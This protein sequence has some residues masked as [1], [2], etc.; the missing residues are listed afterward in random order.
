MKKIYCLLLALY[1]MIMHGCTLTP[2]DNTDKDNVD[3]DLIDNYKKIH[4]NNELNSLNYIKETLEIDQIVSE[5]YDNVEFCS[6]NQTEILLSIWNKNTFKFIRYD[7]YSKEIIWQSQT[8]NY[9]YFIDIYT[10]SGKTY[11]LC[12]DE[13]TPLELLIVDVDTGKEQVNMVTSKLPFHT[14][15]ND[16]IYF[17]VTENKQGK[18]EDAIYK[19]D[20]NAQ[21]S[22]IKN[23]TYEIDEKGKYTGEV[24]TAMNGMDGFLLLQTTKTE[25][26]RMADGNFEIYQIQL[27]TMKE[28]KYRTDKPYQFISG[29][30]KYIIASIHGEDK[31]VQESGVLFELNGNNSY[32]IDKVESGNDI[33]FVTKDDENYLIGTTQELMLFDTQKHNYTIIDQNKNLDNFYAEDEIITYSCGSGEEK[34]II[35]LIKNN[36]YYSDSISKDIKSFIVTELPLATVELLYEDNF[37]VYYMESS[38]YSGRPYQNTEAIVWRLDKNTKNVEKL[39]SFQY[40]IIS[41]PIAEIRND[42]LI[43]TY[44]NKEIAI[45]IISK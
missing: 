18:Y 15:W 33:C 11:A 29:D 12:A 25:H 27:K 36:I 4:A 42:N 31:P 6:A 43:I 39:N 37:S 10:V 8:F 13:G 45:P 40:I 3:I 16:Q 2:K 21:P 32:I 41:R 38:D 5:E 30:G 35:V 24:I 9:K 14:Q 7:R 1:M 44:D 19:Y 23:F 20:F 34:Q 17:S 22:K 26:Q 28:E